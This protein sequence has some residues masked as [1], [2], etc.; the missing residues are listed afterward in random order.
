MNEIDRENPIF[1]E[2]EGVSL[3]PRTGMT[4]Q[5]MGTIS[6]GLHPLGRMRPFAN[7]AWVWVRQRPKALPN[8][9]ELSPWPCPKPQRS[10][11][12]WPDLHGPPPARTRTIGPKHEQS[13]WL[14]WTVLAA[15]TL[16]CGCTEKINR[17]QEWRM[18][19]A[20]GRVSLSTRSKDGLKDIY[21]SGSCWTYVSLKTRQG[22][23]WID[24]LHKE[25]WIGSLI[26]QAAALKSF[27]QLKDLGFLSKAK[28][29]S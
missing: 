6:Q 8:P 1:I 28:R 11:A 17:R 22:M 29:F 14:G 20:A 2:N 5:R 23:E 7:T 26:C 27:T 10:M 12:S 19:S 9:S 18:E 16:R 13:S 25:Q 3:A 24:G 21:G 4:G 15:S